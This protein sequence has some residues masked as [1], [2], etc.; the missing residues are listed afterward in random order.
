M[1]RIFISVWG[2]F[3][4]ALFLGCQ[5]EDRIHVSD[6]CPYAAGDF[7]E[8]HNEGVV[9][10]E[11]GNKQENTVFIIY[12]VN[13][14]STSPKGSMVNLKRYYTDLNGTVE[15]SVA[16]L[17]T[18]N[19]IIMFRPDDTADSLKF[20]L[21]DNSIQTL[22]NFTDSLGLWNRNQNCRQQCYFYK[23]QRRNFYRMPENCLNCL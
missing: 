8:Y 23:Y 14:L 4:L 10:Y 1:S 2:L 12:E 13:S 16:Y 11:D 17:Y 6:Y 9:H 15:D 5:S 20:K 19:R 18:Q 21:G 3:I 22:E 7:L